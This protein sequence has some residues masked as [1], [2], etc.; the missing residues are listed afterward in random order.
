MLIADVQ[1]LD[2][3]GMHFM[4]DSLATSFQLFAEAE[5][6]MGKNNQVY[7]TLGNWELINPTGKFHPKTL[8]LHAHSDKDT[9]RVSFHA[10][11]FGIVLT[12]N[13]DIETMT[14]KF[15]KINEGLTQ[16]LERDSMIDIPS[17]R[18][19]LPDMDL[20][21]TAGK[22]NPITT[23]CNNIILPSTT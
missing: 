2:L 14:D 6:D 4:N 13:A 8:T 20:K 19:L 1:N 18:P 15:T 9:T 5:T 11:D 3:Y 21:I 23:S 17:F 12:G 22:D 16:Q 10:G 7:V